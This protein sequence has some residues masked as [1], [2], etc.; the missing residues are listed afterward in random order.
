MRL[1]SILAA[2]FA[3]A[4]WPVWISGSAVAQTAPPV[5]TATTTESQPLSVRVVAYQIEA[6]LDPARKTVDGQ[7]TL[8]YHNLTGQPL[9]TFPFHLYLN[10]FQPKSTFMTEVRL[11]G[12][13]GTG[14]ESG[15]DRKHYGAIEVRKFEVEGVGDLTNK[16]EFIQPDDRN[17]NDHTVFQV[18][19]PQPV[20]AGVDVTFKIAFH[21]QLPE[22]VERTGYKRDFFMVAQ[23]FPKVGVW[24]H[25]KWNCHQFHATTEFF[26]DFGTFD[27]KTTVPQNYVLGA[28]GDMVSSVNNPDGTKT[29][30]WHGEDI[31]DFSWTASPS[32]HLVED[33]WTSPAGHVVK[34]HLLMSPHHESTTARYL[35]VQKGTLDRF[36]RWYGPYPYDRITIVDPPEGGSDAGGME[37][38]TLYTADTSWFVPSGLKLP[39]LVAEH[40]FGHQYWYGMVATNEFEEAWLDEGIN[41]YTE[42]KIMRSL[43]GKGT[44]EINLWGMT[45]GESGSQRLNYLGVAEDDPL[46][47]YAWQFMSSNSY[48]G[49]TYGKTATVLLTLEGIIGEE[50][51]QQAMHAYFMKYRFTHPTGTDFMNTISEV[52]GQDLSWYFNQ[53]VSGTNILDYEILGLR[54]DRVD[55]YEKNPPKEKK[56]QTLYRDTVLVHRKGDFIMPVDVQIKFDDGSTVNEKWDGRDRWIRYSYDKKAKVTSAEI[57][58]GHKI[59]LD[60]D[61]FNNSYTAEENKSATHKLTTYWLFVTQWA[62]Q[63]AA[64]LA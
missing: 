23:W 54:S 39:E 25:G 5:E 44:N 7:E 45:M 38:P 33:S 2:S 18:T 6:K 37:Y 14:P 42:A 51:M 12:T 4:V 8:T 64:W 52:A 35:Q 11:Y 21:D 24:W 62:A 20:P 55:W 61:F 50:T 15:W 59:L 57:D 17:T 16:M 58:P 19:L 26:A 43:Y 28:C 56:G 9:Q 31:H 29:V 32:F 36:D 3:V 63:L 10:A 34:I 49:N 46:T 48:G 13:R 47:R 30:T 41:S 1:R 40:E 22:V 27:V 53:A 60:K